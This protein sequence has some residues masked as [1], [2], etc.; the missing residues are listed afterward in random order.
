M[1]QRTGDL[2]LAV[3]AYSRGVELRP[4]DYEY[5]LLAQ[6]LDATGEKEQAAAARQKAESLSTDIRSAQRRADDLLGRANSKPH[7]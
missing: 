7:E 3:N 6:A 5:L 2:P 4:M 1:A